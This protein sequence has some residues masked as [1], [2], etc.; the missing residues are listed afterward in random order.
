MVTTW[1]SASAVPNTTSVATRAM[2]L[3]VAVGSGQVGVVIVLLKVRHVAVRR[4]H[5]IRNTTSALVAI[6][7]S[8][9]A[10]VIATILLL[11]VIER[12]GRGLAATALVAGNLTTHVV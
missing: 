7:A 6:V 2:L 10:T 11:V 1:T 4:T 12:A 5:F 3:L 9:V 8:I